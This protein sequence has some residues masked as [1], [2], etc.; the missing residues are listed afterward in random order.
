MES[1]PVLPRKFGR[2]VLFDFIGKGGMAEIY[3]A[4]AKTDLGASRLCVVKQILP[5]LAE[6][7]QFAEMLIH[8][9][10][11]AARLNHA[12]VVQV[13]DLGR[14]DERLFITMDYIEGFDLNELLRRCSRGKVPLP[15]EFALHIVAE[16]LKGLGYAHRRID[17]EGKALGIVHRDVS[18]SNILISLEGDVKLCDFGIARATELAVSTDSG[19]SG[20]VDEAIKGKAGYMSPEHARGEAIDAR[21]DVFAIGIV[22]WELIAGRRMYK[23]EEGK[24][25]LLEQA[26]RAEIP[27]LPLRGFAHEERLRGI[28][29]KALS[30]NRDD[31]YPT[32]AAMLR[33]L[34]AYMAE[35]RMLASPLRLGEWLIDK[36]GEDIVTQRRAR[37]RAI[38]ALDIGAPVSLEPLP[39]TP[40]PLP[41]AMPPP[42]VAAPT[43]SPAIPKIPPAPFLPVGL[44]DAVDRSP[45]SIVGASVDLTPSPPLPVVDLAQTERGARPRSTVLVVTAIVG[46]AVVI[47]IVIA[48]MRA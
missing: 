47:A 46:A 35:S 19:G 37:E 30:M 7:A 18:P 5:E 24:P 28:V 26:R 34:E 40:T 31:R 3:L 8:E 1:R 42:D 32:A 17:D 4:R 39:R 22:L 41:S 20:A 33:D 38:S 9:A 48:L 11:L 13:F 23:V 12:N 36:F 15:F 6:H 29:G 27:E 16:A 43:S 10:K 21:G 2:Y 14:A 44:S 25:S 45:S